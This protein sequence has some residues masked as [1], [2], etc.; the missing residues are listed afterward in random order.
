MHAACRT[1]CQSELPPPPPPPPWQLGLQKSR[2]QKQSYLCLSP[3]DA[4]LHPRACW[5]YCPWSS[6]RSRSPGFYP[7]SLLILLLPWSCSVPGGGGR[8]WWWR[9]PLP[10]R[11]P[12]LP[13][14]HCGALLCG[15][16]LLRTHTL[17]H[18]PLNASLLL[19]H[20]IFADHKIHPHRFSRANLTLEFYDLDL[21][22]SPG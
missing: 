19:Q 2:T 1:S 22:W 3:A 9:R 6:R 20:I 14:A 17:T 8:W 11:L 5:D 16:V 10:A 4:C 7:P 21:L 18:T 15:S 12:R 13:P